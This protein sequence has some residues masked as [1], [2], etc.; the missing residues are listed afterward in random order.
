MKKLLLT[1]LAALLLATGT[2]HAAEVKKDLLMVVLKEDGDG[3]SLHQ[4]LT[5]DCQQFLNAF[6]QL[7]KNGIAGR[8]R[9]LSPPVVNGEVLKAY[10]IHPDGSI[11]HG[12]E[13][14]Q[15][16]ICDDET[17]RKLIENA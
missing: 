2:A 15:Y 6:R 16:E 9:F 14:T 17:E 13:D 1:T 4:Q 8:L 11:E 12:G 7:K 5:S 3:T 10:C